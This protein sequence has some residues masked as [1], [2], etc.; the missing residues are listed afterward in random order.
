VPVWRPTGRLEYAVVLL[1]ATVNISR[2]VS[3]AVAR[4]SVDFLFSFDP[5][6][7]SSCIVSAVCLSFAVEA[8]AAAVHAVGAALQHRDARFLSEWMSKRASRQRLRVL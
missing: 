2:Q 6:I 8:L 5:Q 4:N 7:M 3:V 1:A